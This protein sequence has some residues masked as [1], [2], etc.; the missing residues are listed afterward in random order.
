MTRTIR[1]LGITTLAL[2]LAALAGPGL[3]SAKTE[4]KKVHGNITISYEKN[5][6]GGED[7]FFGL[8]NSPNPRC[9]SSARVD[10]GFRPAFEGGGS[11][12]FPRTIVASTRADTQGNW[13]ILYKVT[14]NQPTTSSPTPPRRRSAR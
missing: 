9:R 13:Q 4:K 3:A 12:E 1:V 6:S 10:L 8:V 2:A 14:P 7:R 11:S 5:A